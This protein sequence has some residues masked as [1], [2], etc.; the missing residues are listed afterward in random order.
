VTKSI[1]ANNLNGCFD[2]LVTGTDATVDGSWGGSGL[3][4]AW[5]PDSISTDG[6]TAT[7][8]TGASIVLSDPIDA[9]WC[10]ARAQ[11]ILDSVDLT[12]LVLGTDSLLATYDPAFTGS[13]SPGTAQSNGYLAL[14][15]F[16]DGVGGVKYAWGDV[17]GDLLTTDGNIA[18][19]SF[20]PFED[21]TPAISYAA[22][23]LDFPP[24]PGSRNLYSQEASW[25]MRKSISNMVSAPVCCQDDFT[26]YATTGLPS[27]VCQ[28]IADDGSGHLILVP[29]SLTFDV[30]D[31]QRIV[32]RTP[33][34]GTALTGGGCPCA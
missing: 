13:G 15:V 1:S 30:L 6:L 9:A 16:G 28:M 21:V 14:G 25:Q 3:Y 5:P 23:S 34:F 10:K 19:A 24:S 33:Y 22:N 7:W 11:D 18:G 26:G 32:A 17:L 2:D 12:T 4:L 31:T 27:P 29:P 8:G 20:L